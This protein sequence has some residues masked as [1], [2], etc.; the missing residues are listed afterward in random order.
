MSAGKSSREPCLALYLVGAFLYTLCN[1]CYSLPLK[2][3]SG[4]E[5]IMHCALCFARDNDGEQAGYGP[6]WNGAPCLT[7]GRWERNRATHMSIKCA[8]SYVGPVKPH[9]SCKL[10]Q[11]RYF[12]SLFPIGKYR[13]HRQCLSIKRIP[14]VC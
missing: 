4:Q 6:R 5:P 9:C 8:L 2:N 3:Q 10:G 12:T 14:C 7:G 11:D 1:L 13:L